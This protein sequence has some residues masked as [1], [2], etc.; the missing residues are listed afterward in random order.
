MLRV[1]QDQPVEPDVASATQIE[2]NR[3]AAAVENDG[4]VRRPL[5]HDRML[6][7]ARAPD[8]ERRFGVD[9]RA[10]REDIARPRACE[11]CAQAAEGMVPCSVTAGLA[12]GGERHDVEPA[13]RR[14]PSGHGRGPHLHLLGSRSAVGILKPK[15]DLV[16]RVG[17]EVDDASGEEAPSGDPVLRR[18]FLVVRTKERQGGRPAGSAGRTVGDLDHGVAVRVAEN[19]PA[20]PKA[21]RGRRLNRDRS[22]RRGVARRG[23]GRLRVGRGGKAAETGGE[24]E[25]QPVEVEPPPE[26]RLSGRCLRR[27][28]PA[29]WRPRSVGGYCVAT[30]ATARLRSASGSRM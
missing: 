7:R 17:N 30:F 8:D 5:E 9:P 19:G 13:E 1:A 29:L 12:S 26:A 4:P 24:D 14:R 28:S 6:G 18:Q 22:G 21:R 3:T 20:H 25:N 16:F 23:R 27:S 10:E 11:G 2:E 15:L